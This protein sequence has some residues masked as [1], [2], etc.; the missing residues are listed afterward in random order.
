[1]IWSSDIQLVATELKECSICSLQYEMTKWSCPVEGGIEAASPSPLPTSTSVSQRNPW[2]T[3]F[4]NH[5]PLGD[6]K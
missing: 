4:E 1:M 2:E 3:H 6:R 5:R